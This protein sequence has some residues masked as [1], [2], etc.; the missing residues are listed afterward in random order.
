MTDTARQRLR[1]IEKLGQAV[2]E[3]R[4]ASRIFPEAREQCCKNVDELTRL[5]LKVLET[6]K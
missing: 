4:L 6:G 1:L 5:T 2:H 3:N